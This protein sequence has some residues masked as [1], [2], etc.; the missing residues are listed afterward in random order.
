MFLKE[1]DTRMSITRGSSITFVSSVIIFVIGLGTSVILARLLGPGGRGIYSI[2][3]LVPSLLVTIGGLSIQAAIVYFSANRKYQLGDIVFSSLVLGF[4]LGII[5]I[6]IFWVVS[7]TTVFREFVQVNGINP[8]HLWL[9]VSATPLALLYCFFERVL[10]GREEIVKFNSARI[11]RSTLH[12]GL[13]IIFLIVLRHG[14]PGAIASHILALVGATLLVIFLITRFTGI[15]FSMNSAFVK[16]SIRY[17]SKVHLGVI[18]QFLNYRLDIFLIA[19]FLSVAEVGCYAVAVGLAERLWMIPGSIGTV[20]FPRVSAIESARANQLTPRVSRNT[21]FIT[22]IL[23]LGLMVLAKPLIQFL[24]GERF[25]YSIKPLM[26]LLPGI[27]AFSVCK[28]LA[29]DLAGRGRPEFN[30]FAALV[31]LGVN[32]PLNLL[33]IPTW[34]I[35]G[36]AFASTVAYTIASIFSI[37]M[38]VKLTGSSLNNILL[39]KGSDF[40]TYSGVLSRALRKR[41]EV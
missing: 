13:I 28:V 23:S 33:L 10:L 22:F 8:L 20:L 2:V 35:S 12:F 27:V 16:E 15:T 26:I 14:L 1:S 17:G 32:I 19:H 25:L 41:R 21:L 39:I 30:G 24:F 31:S 34:G 3:L 5:L 37:I 18:A 40:K 7:K 38:F 4:I 29:N 9:V 36:A 11:F 6:S